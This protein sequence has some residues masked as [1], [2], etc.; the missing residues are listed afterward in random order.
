MGE[1]CLLVI[2]IRGDVNI[3]ARERDTLR[4]LRLKKKYSATLLDDR[5]EYLGM[6]QKVKDFVTWGEPSIETINLLL[7]K[8]GKVTGDSPVNSETVKALGY[9]NI[10][11]LASAIHSVEAE[12]HKLENI[13]PF[14]RL[15]PPKKGFKRSVK[16]SYRNTGE[17][18]YREET[19]NYLARR[20][21]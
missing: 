6:L 15:H 13:K 2:R 9:K 11:E 17:L 18:G 3:S 19:I 16:R 4:M 1:K 21:C 14:F 8:R 12:F 10:N 20:M 5:P 7:E